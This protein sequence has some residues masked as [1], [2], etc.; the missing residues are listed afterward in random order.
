VILG[1]AG[2]AGMAAHIQHAVPVPVID[3]VLAGARQAQ[4]WGALGDAQLAGAWTGLSPAL[5]Q[6]ATV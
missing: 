3:S 5:M 6:I 1:G 2:L 4:H